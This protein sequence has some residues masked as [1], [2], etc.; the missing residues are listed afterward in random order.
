V[1]QEDLASI[2]GSGGQMDGV[3]G[4]KVVHGLD[5]SGSAQSIGRYGQH[6][7]IGPREKAVVQPQQRETGVPQGKV[8]AFHAR[9]LAQ[10]AAIRGTDRL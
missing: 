3:N 1:G 8:A 5:E 10:S 7:D 6:D 4:G 2:L 9:K